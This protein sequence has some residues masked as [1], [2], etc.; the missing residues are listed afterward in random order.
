MVKSSL[1]SEE[2][3]KA[4]TSTEHKVL[5][6]RLRKAAERQGLRLEKSRTRDPHAIDYGTYQLVDA[7]RNI[8]KRDWDMDRGFG[9]DLRSVGRYLFADVAV[10]VDPVPDYGPDP[11]PGAW[12]AGVGEPMTFDDT[13]A[14]ILQ[15]RAWNTT[16]LTDDTGALLPDGWILH[17]ADGEE[18][19][20]SNR[21]PDAVDEVVAD[22]KEYIRRYMN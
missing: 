9:L 20:M 12:N 21:F 16:Q 13:E 6:N 2:E 15:F 8:V 17:T 5:E 1:P 18:R 3:I 7:R 22:A 10:R 11:A 19:I 4:M 14:P